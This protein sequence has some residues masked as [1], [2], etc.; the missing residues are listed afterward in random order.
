MILHNI[1]QHSP[2]M[3]QH[4]PKTTQHSPNMVPRWASLALRLP[5]IIS[6]WPQDGPRRRSLGFRPEG[7]AK[8]GNAAGLAQSG[9]SG[10]ACGHRSYQGVRRVMRQVGVCRVLRG[11]RDISQSKRALWALIGR[12]WSSST[13]DGAPS[14]A[15]ACGCTAEPS[16]ACASEMHKAGVGAGNG[17][18]ET[19]RHA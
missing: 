19:G 12:V 11:K 5:K 4:S 18:V 15:E 14:C 16:A 13:P 1:C 6:R 2:R 8:R 10:Q 3:G 9:W 7:W 17:G